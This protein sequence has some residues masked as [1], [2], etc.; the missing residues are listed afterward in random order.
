MKRGIKK[1]NIYGMDESGFP[2]SHQGMEQVIGR[3]GLK[4]QHKAGSVNH[5]NVTALV[6]ICADR[7]TLKPTIIFKGRNFMK[8][9]GEDNL[10]EAS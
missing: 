6:T 3:R 1:H 2:P 4:I 10:S 9:W 5:K 8:S 7:M